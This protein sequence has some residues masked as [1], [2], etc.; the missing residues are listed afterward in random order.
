MKNK[1]FVC[2]SII[3]AVILAFLFGAV[4]TVYSRPMEDLSLDLSLIDKNQHIADSST[5]DS[6]GW[7][8]FVQHGDEKKELNS[9]GNGSYTGIE[10][11]ETL[12][13]SRVM[14][15]ALDSPTLQIGTG[16]RN[17]SVWL[18]GALIYTDLPELDN[19]IG[20]LTLPMSSTYRQEPIN[21]SLP[22]GYRGKTLTIA[23][24]TPPYSETPT[25]KAVPASVMLYC[26]YA[27]ESGI[28]AE[29]FTTALHATLVFVLGVMLLLVFLHNRDWCILCLSL[30]A[31]MLQ[32]MVL[33]DVSF[34]GKYMGTDFMNIIQYSRLAASVALTVFMALK[35][36]KGKVIAWGIGA[37]QAVTV[38]FSV[39]IHPLAEHSVNRTLRFFAFSLMEWAALAG[40]IAVLLLGMLYWR[41]ENGF[42]RLFAPCALTVTVIGWIW[43]FITDKQILNTVYIGI[44]SAQVTALYQKTFTMFVITAIICAV[45]D[46]V[47]HEFERRA[48]KR[49]LEQHMEAALGSY[50]NMRRQHEEI[51]MLRHDLAGH[52]SAIKE[53]AGKGE[54]VT[55]YI[56]ELIGQNAN[57]RTVV[58]T[59]NNT[60]DIILNNKLGRAADA[61]IKVEVIKAEAPSV[62]PLTDADLCSLVMNIADNAIKAA[63]FGEKGYVRLDIHVKNDYFAISVENSV[64]EKE[65]TKKAQAVPGHGLGLRIVHGIAEKYNG[66]ISTE[67]TDGAYKVR[68]AIP[69]FSL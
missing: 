49:L 21:I 38:L 68:I 53:L 48:E 24:S 33:A 8:V 5:F 69:L 61:G 66:L 60:L 18:D 7:T 28:V 55:A 29:S 19:R 56:D 12:Y 1:L 37:F 62:L 57:V 35:A 59:G 50:E 14:A 54:Q 51:M 42:F 58:S 34:F 67:Q 43:L 26:G 20:E 31:F 44:L 41:K 47:K 10:L 25:L 63:S 2:L 4:L 27:Y 3:C 32:C 16:E 65:K 23:Q 40:I 9:L 52:L 15:E 45:V 11:G 17:Y 6:K 39:L 22:G 30:S 36:G 46:A 13:F 64:S